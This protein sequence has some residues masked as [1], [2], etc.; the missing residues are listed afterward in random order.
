MDLKIHVH[1]YRVKLLLA[2]KN[3]RTAKRE[4]R[5]IQSAAPTNITAL[6]MKAQ[7]HV[8]QG[9][10]KKGAQILSRCVEGT[11][12]PSSHRV[13]ALCNMGVI[14]HQMKKHNSA[15]LCFSNALKQL[16]EIE[17]TGISAEVNTNYAGLLR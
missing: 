10:L 16:A 12:E 4:F 14:Y 13:A 7:L 17:A 6:F 2:M 8:L 15:C 11:P 5:C 1:L 9:K 3:I